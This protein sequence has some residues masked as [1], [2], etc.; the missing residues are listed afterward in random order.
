VAGSASAC[1][2]SKLRATAR[3]PPTPQ[4]GDGQL[5]HHREGHPAGAER[6]AQGGQGRDAGDVEQREH[7]EGQ[8]AAGRQDAREALAVSTVDGVA[9]A[10][11]A[12]QR[13]ERV[14]RGLEQADAQDRRARR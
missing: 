11:E 10:A 13:G 14:A 8:G 7:H 6:L 2:T 5:V 3:T 12:P 4:V 1:S 9:A